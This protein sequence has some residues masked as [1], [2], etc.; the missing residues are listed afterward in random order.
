[1]ASTR[2]YRTLAAN[3]EKKGA[4]SLWFK[5][6]SGLGTDRVLICSYYDADYHSAIK[7]NTDDCLNVFDWRSGMVSNYTTTRKLRDVSAWYH[8]VFEWDT[9]QV[10]AGDRNKLYINGVQETLFT[11]STDYSSDYIPSWN[12]DYTLSIGARNSDQ[13]WNGEMSHL[14]F[15]QGYAYAASTFG[16]TDAT[17]GIWK[18]NTG[19]S[20]NYTGT[21]TNSSFLKMEDRTNL[22]LDSGSNANTFTTGGTGTATYDNPSNNFCTMNPLRP[23][24]ISQTYSNG[25]NTFIRTG[26]GGQMNG[27]LGITKGKWYYECLIDDYWQYIGWTVPSLNTS[28]TAACSDSGSG[29]YGVYAN[30]TN[31]SSYAN[32]VNSALTGYTVMAAAQYISIAFDADNGEL[33]YGTNGVWG[34]SS[35]PVTRT[36]PFLTSVPVT[37]FVVPAIGQGTGSRSST[38]KMNFGNGYFGTTSSG[39][40]E[41]DDAGIGQFKYDDTAGI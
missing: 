17:S 36:N 15:I 22:D 9:T 20:V 13:Y 6:G 25:N 3:S 4:I 23:N 38:I 41:A 27:T 39:T 5:I 21:G 33:Y 29:F 16:S 32:G 7:L 12:R 11:S 40:T 19:A 26:T 34:N 10:S 37:D 18:I 35:N 28:Q 2:V 14:Y 8:V 30:A 1:M 31:M 24:S